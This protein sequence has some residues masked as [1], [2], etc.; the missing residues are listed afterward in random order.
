M[1]LATSSTHKLHICLHSHTKS[2]PAVIS[3]LQISPSLKWDI[4]VHA[5]R[6]EAS[7][8]PMLSFLPSTIKTAVDVNTILTCVNK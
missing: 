4:Y 5:V 6:I 8:V 3:T 1:V 2:Q 7:S